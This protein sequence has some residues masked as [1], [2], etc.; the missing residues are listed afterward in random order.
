ML[1]ATPFFLPRET[2]LLSIPCALAV[3]PTKPKFCLFASIMA[4]RIPIFYLP[5][6]TK[7]MVLE[8]Q[9][10]IQND[11]ATLLVSGISLD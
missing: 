1:L 7:N 3:E 2:A 10:R 5:E 11:E 9:L 4:L 6:S 8:S